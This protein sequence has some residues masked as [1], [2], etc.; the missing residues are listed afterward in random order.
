[1]FVISINNIIFVFKMNINKEFRY[2][3]K[4]NYIGSFKGIY[5]MY[6]IWQ[7]CV[8]HDKVIIHYSNG[9]HYTNTNI[10]DINQWLQ[11]MRYEPIKTK[12]MN[13]D[14]RRIINK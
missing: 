8:D 5:D 4:Q 7:S 9:T 13:E 14:W 3:D 11:S 10:K 1:M 6:S 2:K 12:Y